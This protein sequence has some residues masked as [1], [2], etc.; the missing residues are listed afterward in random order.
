MLQKRPRILIKSNR[1]NILSKHKSG[2]LVGKNVTERLLER[3]CII[4][5]VLQVLNY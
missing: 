5:R 3:K 2:T 4:L 1:V